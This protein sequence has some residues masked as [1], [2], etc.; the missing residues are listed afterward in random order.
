MKPKFKT[1]CFAVL[2]TAGFSLGAA[3]ALSYRSE[4]PERLSADSTYTLTLGEGVDVADT[5]GTV[6]SASGTT[7]GF[8]FTDYSKGSGT[9]GSFASGGELLNW[10]AFH[11]IQSITVRNTS[12]TLAFYNGWKQYDSSDIEYSSSAYQ[13]ISGSGTHA[14]D[15][16][17]IDP[18]YFKLVAT[19]DCAIDSISIVYTCA[20]TSVNS[21]LRIRVA[22]PTI[23]GEEATIAA[24]NYVWINTNVKDAGTWTNYV[25]TRDADGSWY[26][27][28]NNVSAAS[29]GYTYS[30]VVCDSNS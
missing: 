27:D 11:S 1:I 9:L 17:S 7:F 16:S 12:G 24:S 22:K 15:L 18:S 20:S 10:D 26:A 8:K 3:Y 13:T 25:M 6:T 28:F 23:G 4:T 21:N 30:L 5:Y 14:I 19:S 29:S 2:A